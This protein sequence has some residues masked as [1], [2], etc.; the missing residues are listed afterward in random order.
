MTVSCGNAS[1]PASKGYVSEIGAGDDADSY[2]CA[3]SEDSQGS[4]DEDE[5]TRDRQ[6]TANTEDDATKGN[7]EA[8]P[9]TPRSRRRTAAKA[10]LA[11]EFAR[12]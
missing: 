7:D 2:V 3:D 5:E 8:L 4:Q 1:K 6:W 12:N 11:Q 9:L 10:K